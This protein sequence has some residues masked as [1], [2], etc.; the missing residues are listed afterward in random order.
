MPRLLHQ[1]ARLLHLRVEEVGRPDGDRLVAPDY[2][3]PQLGIDRA[4]RTAVQPVQV[5]LQLLR[6]G[7]EPFAA[8]HVVHGL[9]RDHLAERRDERRIADVPAHMVGFVENFVQAV[10]RVLRAE[11][12]DDLLEHEAWHVVAEDAR[13]DA[14][15][16]RTQVL[17]MPLL[18]ILD[19]LLDLPHHA[20]VQAGVVLAAL[21]RR[22]DALRGRLRGAPGERRDGHVEDLGAGLDRSHVRHRRHAA[23]A[24]RVDVDRNLD[25]VLEGG[26][27]LPC[28]LRTEQ[29]RS[30]LDDDLVAAHLHEALRERRPQLDV[31]RW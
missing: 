6:D 15:R 18:E 2:L 5:I 1:L 28:G 10:A 22:D 20:Q 9:G 31:V 19:V 24:V 8:Q 11:L 21:E 14:V 12:A 13:V 26:D 25:R 23:R 4:G 7:G 29:T 30:V 3:P 17:D 16:H 27:E